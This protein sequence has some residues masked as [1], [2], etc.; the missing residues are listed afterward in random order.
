MKMIPILM[1][2]VGLGVA[3]LLHAVDN[4]PPA[5]PVAVAES[6]LFE[7]VGRLEMEGL[8]WFVDRAETNAPVLA[9]RLEVEAAGKTI[10]AVF[11]PERGDYLINDS[12]WLKTLRQPGE[13]ALALTL[14]AGEESDLLATTLQVDAA[15]LGE[16]PTAFG[17][18][19]M[20]GAVLGLLGMILL[21]RRLRRGGVA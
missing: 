20:A 3:P 4:V 7:A 12:D 6:E 1:L 19:A 2:T 10:Q 14:V 8:S 17:R 5:V 13:H 16:S 21:G 11:R 15:A 18:R 9:A